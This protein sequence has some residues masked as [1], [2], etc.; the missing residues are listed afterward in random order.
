MR[1]DIIIVKSIGKRFLINMH[2]S[3]NYRLGSLGVWRVLLAARNI[4]G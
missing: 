1:L 2:P 4:E 3:A